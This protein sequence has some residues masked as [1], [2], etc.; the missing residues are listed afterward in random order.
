YFHG[1]DSDTAEQ[2]RS[3]EEGDVPHVGEVQLS[4]IFKSSSQKT[5]K[6]AVSTPIYRDAARKEFIGVLVYT[7]NVGD[8]AFF[9]L[10]NEIAA[11]HY[12][13]LVDGRPGPS[14][15]SILQHQLFIDLAKV[16][17]KPPEEIISMRV[18][19]E[20]LDTKGDR[21]YTD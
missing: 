13:V 7:I 10:E 21:L 15:G 1:G 9:R 11:D 16:G 8:F 19:E 12:A 3:P 2:P 18:P 20:V 4:A 5:W 6:V 14:R 17:Q